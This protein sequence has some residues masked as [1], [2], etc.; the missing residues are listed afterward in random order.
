LNVTVGPDIS[1]VTTL[2][3]IKHRENAMRDVFEKYALG[4]GRPDIAKYVHIQ[5]NHETRIEIISKMTESKPRSV[6]AQQSIGLCL[7]WCGIVLLWLLAGGIIILFVGG[8]RKAIK[9]HSSSAVVRG[10]V[11]NLRW[12]AFASVLYLFTLVIAIPICAPLQRQE[13][14]KVTQGDL[15][16]YSEMMKSP[17]MRHLQ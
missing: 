8:I 13:M 3:K 16:F 9:A 10:H 17:F 5:K 14:S 6:A 11:G 1:D 15:V 4:H 12:V 7:W 2:Q